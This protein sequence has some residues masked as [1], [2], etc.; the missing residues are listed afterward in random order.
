METADGKQRLQE[1][2]GLFKRGFDD[3][4]ERR[5]SW[6]G[7]VDTVLLPTLQ[8][9]AGQLPEM[10]KTRS[11]HVH[12]ERQMENLEAVW[13]QL[14]TVCNGIAVEDD[15][16]SAVGVEAGAALGF[17]LDDHARVVVVAYPFRSSLPRRKEERRRPYV[18]RYYESAVNVTQE[19]IY[20][21]VVSFL[22]WALEHSVF[23]PTKRDE[24]PIKATA[25]EWVPIEEADLDG[26][27]PKEPMGFKSKSDD[28]RSANGE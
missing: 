13:L 3:T 9:I 6:S 11:A 24:I 26:L 4:R 7:V 1:L 12:R 20:E 15:K 8:E 19:D 10:E 18:G 14:G 21:L 22:A 17:C 5:Q 25:I 27:L 28:S 23:S 2:N 16:G